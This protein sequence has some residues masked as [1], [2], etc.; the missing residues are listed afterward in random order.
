MTHQSDGVTGI[1]FRAALGLLQTIQKGACR[2]ASP[3]AGERADNALLDSGTSSVRLLLRSIGQN[4]GG[5]AL[6]STVRTHFFGL[7]SSSS[8]A[9]ATMPPRKKKSI[10]LPMVKRIGSHHDERRVADDLSPDE[11]PHIDVPMRL[12]SA[13]L[14]LCAV[15]PRPPTMSRETLSGAVPIA[16][17]LLD[18]VPSKHQAV[19]ALVLVAILEA[20]SSLEPEA[21]A[22]LLEKCSSVVHSSLESAIRQCGRDEPILFA[23]ICLA[24]S[25]WITY[26]TFCSR[27]LDTAISPSAVLAVTR[28][29]AVD[30]LIAVRKQAQTG[31]RDGNDERIARALVAG[32]NPLL[33]QLD[34]FPEAAS[35]EIARIGLSALLPVLGWS[36]MRPAVRTAQVAGM[37]SLVALMHGSAPVMPRHGMKIMT[38]LLLLL[39]R[40]DKDAAFLSCDKTLKSTDGGSADSKISTEATIHI[41]LWTA[42]IALA[43]CGYSAERVLV[44]V[45]KTHSSRQTLLDRCAEIRALV[46][47]CSNHESCTE[48]QKEVHV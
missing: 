37:T 11:K 19:G 22:F 25:R 47:T 7:P 33:A 1:G 12:A 32:V 48:S 2:V 26:F 14:A 29:A 20:A 44:H 43:I 28:K 3:R 13:A 42:S 23:V 41:A 27:N 31:G 8:D 38:T 6:A 15:L 45:E 17:S 9:E 46:K 4:V 40:T 16:L 39:D 36:G 21:S 34:R 24:Q 5:D 18:D 35:V 30:I 10:L